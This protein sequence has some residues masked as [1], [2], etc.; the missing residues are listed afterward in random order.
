VLR[1]LTTA[2]VCAS[3]LHA[4]ETE[5]HVRKTA[6]V[7]SATGLTLN[8]EVG[9]IRIQPGDEKRV[10]VEVYFRGD[11]PSRGEFDRMLRD[12]TLD[13]VQEGSD[14]RVTGAFHQ[15]WKPMLSVW[16]VIFGHPICR[17]GQCLE[18]STWLRDV[19]YRVTVPH[20]FNAQ[21]E[22]SGGSISV[23]DLKGDVNAHTSGGSLNFNHIDG[24]V[25]GR[26][27]GGSIT[28]ASGNGRA[29]LHTSGGSI[30]IREV[31]GDVDAYTSGGG[32]SIERAA[33][34]VKAHT[35]GGSIEVREATGAIDA[36]TSGGG[37]T[38]SLLGQP[39]EECRLSTSGGSINVSL[40]KDVH[41]DLDASTSGGSVWT[42]FPVP[43]DG[44]K[45]HRE[46]H[47]PLNGG[48]PLLYLH[49]SG[50][51]ISVRRTG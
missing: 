19:E 25:N 31:G 5:D 38:A 28:L 10:E 39:K 47:A 37:V 24:P 4:A 35:S 12:F 36:S 9:S 18:Y 14:V 41:V 51:G 8:A 11:P 34:R 30:Q 6:P 33:G 44:E 40:A 1:L 22:T 49:T 13:V 20:K 21:A 17:N 7:S 43:S 15:G 26:T 46:L 48:G 23:S 50:G 45:H 2:L 3:F 29:L 32:I 42:D 16:P 27:S